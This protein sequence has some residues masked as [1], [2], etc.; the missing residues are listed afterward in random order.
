[1]KL[2]S[3]DK[4][5]LYRGTSA[6]RYRERDSIGIFMS[7]TSRIRDGVAKAAAVVPVAIVDNLL[8]RGLRSPSSTDAGV[9]TTS[10]HS[11]QLTVYGMVVLGLR[12][13]LARK[14]RAEKLF[15]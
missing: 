8:R 5:G 15:R 10:E 14:H 3:F 13:R 11:P 6:L 9:T 1:M 2:R 4:A 7:A 12:K